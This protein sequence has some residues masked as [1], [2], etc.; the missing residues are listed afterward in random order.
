MI[1]LGIDPGYA[2]LGYGVIKKKGNQFKELTHGAIRTSADKDLLTRYMTLSDDLQE[3]IDEYQ[4]TR[5]GIEKL[6]FNKNVKT[7][8]NVAQ[9]RGVVLLLLKQND[10]VVEE[11]TPGE[12]KKGVT[13]YGR[14]GKKQVQKMVKALLGL[15]KIPRPDD[16]SDALAVAM[17]SGQSRSFEQQIS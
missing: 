16:A 9:A 17:C 3:I 14:A 2:T 10:L 11:F 13:G 6:Y 5:C 1:I 15:P 8:I 7:A 4:P 12:I